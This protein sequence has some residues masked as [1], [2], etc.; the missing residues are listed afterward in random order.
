MG[1]SIC[2][3][4]VGQLECELVQ[5]SGVVLA[6]EVMEL[7]E[8]GEQQQACRDQ[9]QGELLGGQDDELGQLDPHISH[10]HGN[11]YHLQCR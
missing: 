4:A 6:S 3:V 2:D 9:E 11:R 10:Q 5:D 8:E 1:V 7:D